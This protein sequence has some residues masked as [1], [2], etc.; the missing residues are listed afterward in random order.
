MI[1]DHNALALQSGG[2]S[3]VLSPPTSFYFQAVAAFALVAAAVACSLGVDLSATLPTMIACAAIL[4]FGLPHGALDLELL[5][6][7]GGG[8]SLPRPLLFA[9]YLAFAGATYGLWCREP[10]VALGAFLT[11]AVVHFSD[12]WCACRAPLLAQGMALATLTAPLLFHH[13]DIDA[14]FVQLSG[15]RSVTVFVDVLMLLAPVA[16]LVGAV[17]CLDLWKND[18]ESDAVASGITLVAMLTLPPVIGF[19]I[20]FCFLHSPAHLR[21][22][23]LTLV[24]RA[25]GRYRAPLIVAISAAM[26]VAAFGLTALIFSVEPHVTND[27]PFFRATFILLSI[28]TVP[29][30]LMPHLVAAILDP[31]NRILRE[32]CEKIICTA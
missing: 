23:V 21:D 6:A 19:A 11:V 18:R 1:A 20:Y 14:L 24:E 12:D 32:R 4:I 28:L 2:E 7:S 22:N 10:L 26:T 30:M 9:A 31:D 8:R 15:D 13:T 3:R 16:V 25:G 5:Q 17:A 29:H 27:A